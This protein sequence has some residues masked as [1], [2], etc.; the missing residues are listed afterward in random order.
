MLLADLTFALNQGP[1][2]NECVFNPILAENQYSILTAHAKRLCLLACHDENKG[3]VACVNE[4]LAQVDA[5]LS[6]YL[7]ACEKS[8]E[9]LELSLSKL[10]A[11][12]EEIDESVKEQLLYATGER[13]REEEEERKDA[14]SVKPVPSEGSDKAQYGSFKRSERPRLGSVHELKKKF[15]VKD[16]VPVSP[17]MSPMLPVRSMKINKPATSQESPTEKQPPSPL[18][19]SLQPSS[20]TISKTRITFET[21][22]PPH[23]PTLPV[24][25]VKSQVSPIP[26]PPLVKKLQPTHLLPADSFES[27]NSLPPTPP[28]LPPGTPPRPPPPPDTPV[29]FLTDEEGEKNEE[30]EE[31]KIEGGSIENKEEITEESTV[32]EHTSTSLEEAN[33]ELMENNEVEV[34][35]DDDEMLPDLIIPHDF[36]DDAYI[37]VYEEMLLSKQELGVNKDRVTVLGREEGLGSQ[38]RIL[39]PVFEDEEYGRDRPDAGHS[40][41]GGSPRRTSKTRMNADAQWTHAHRQSLQSMR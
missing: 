32:I 9:D 25:T 35:E 20:P 16:D 13:K 7:V 29:S 1:E 39:S 21:S 5:K 26:S 33:P 10:D 4:L 11:F 3:T 30:E 14:G 8:F 19:G 34:E 2:L 38:T 28:P 41:G 22:P 36:E 12:L 24:S 6:V 15:E 23:S 17:A 27:D 18:K 37:D 40:G 31:E